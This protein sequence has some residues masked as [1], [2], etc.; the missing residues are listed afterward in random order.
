MTNGVNHARITTMLVIP[1]TMA[2]MTV[3]QSPVIGL[4][5]GIGVLCGALV[6]GVAHKLKKNYAAFSSVLV[7]GAI[8]ILYF[9]CPWKGMYM[10]AFHFPEEELLHYDTCRLKF[11]T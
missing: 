4:C 8:S 7:A 3:T 5:V 1:A 2:G 10:C 6:M 11:A 9:L